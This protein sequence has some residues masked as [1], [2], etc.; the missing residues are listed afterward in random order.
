VAGVFMFVSINELLVKEFN[1]SEQYTPEEEVD[2][3]LTL[4]KVSC[5]IGGISTG[6]GIT[7]ISRM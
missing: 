4:K 7:V 1:Q 3:Y 5:L 2:N 6:I